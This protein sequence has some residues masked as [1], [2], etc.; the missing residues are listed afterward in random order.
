VLSIRGRM[1][2]SAEPL[3]VD[4]VDD[5]RQPADS[6]DPIVEQLSRI[7]GMLLADAPSRDIFAAMVDDVVEDTGASLVILRIAKPG[8]D[9]FEAKARAGLESPRPGPDFTLSVSSATLQSLRR[10]GDSFGAGFVVDPEHIHGEEESPVPPGTDW[11]NG[12]LLIVTIEADGRPVGFF[13]IGF[14]DGAPGT[15]IAS[16]LKLF[17]D[18]ALLVI[19]RDRYRE[20]LRTKERALAVCKE[21]LDGLNQLKSNFLSVVSHELRTPLT[22]IKAYR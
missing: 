22:S 16:I 4:G 13:T 19:K 3:R 5:P 15:R 11:Q 10:K 9:V 12:K 2:K 8:G 7:S 20:I 14:F 1:R 18:R 6:L 17:T 21:E